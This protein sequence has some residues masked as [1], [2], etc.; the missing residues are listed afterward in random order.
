MYT[1]LIVLIILFVIH[2]HGRCSIKK[3]FLN[4]IP[5]MLKFFSFFLGVF[6]YLFKLYVIE[7]IIS[8]DT[9]RM[10]IMVQKKQ[11]CIYR[12]SLI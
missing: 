1:H 3:V 7:Y 2:Y 5:V 4:K 12:L 10:T 9:F 11:W 6:L 8:V